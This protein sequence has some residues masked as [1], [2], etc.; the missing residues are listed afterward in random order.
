MGRLLHDLSL[1]PARSFQKLQASS[2]QAGKASFSFAWLLDSTDSERSRGI[3]V[4]IASTTFSTPKT[5]FTI[6]DAPGH[7]DF[8]PNMIAGTSQADFAVLV[9]DSGTGA[10]E[11]GMEGGGQTKEHTLL[12]RALGINRVIVAVNKMDTTTPP[13]SQARFDTVS[14][15]MSGF[16][17]TAGFVSKNT[18]F[19]PCAGLTGQNVVERLPAET[20]GKPAPWSWYAGPTLL[21]QLD[22]TGMDTTATSK[23]YIASPLRLT[24]S[25]IFRASVTAP[26]SISARIDA[27]S[28]QI[29][30]V[31]LA[32]PAGETA[33]I[34]GLEVDSSSGAAIPSD[35][36]NPEDSEN[37]NKGWAVAGQIITAHLADIDPIHLRLGDVM[38]SLKNPIRNVRAFSAKILAFDFVIPGAVDC[39]RGK[40]HAEANIE[41][42]L[43]VLDKNGAPEGKKGKKPRVVK[44]GAVARVRVELVRYL[45]LEAGA[46]VVLRRE[47]TT[48]AAG[49]VEH[50]E[51]V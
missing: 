40:M 31:V 22:T 26:L 6:L 18:A 24:I 23:Q 46:R 7:K 16:L 5:N 28:L 35:A 8:V 38:C 49:L 43:A 2:Q 3:T 41:S 42:L 48:V 32:M 25:D 44:A 27:G 33:T 15:Q 20:K 10:F 50:V 47:G 34:K 51:A 11:T 12:A 36:G 30:D 17:T 4:D 37:A 21:E 1:I 13:W 14:Q 19:V 29:G 45:P 9:L 39:H